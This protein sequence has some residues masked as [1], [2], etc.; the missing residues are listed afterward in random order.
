MG[1]VCRQEVSISQGVV[2]LQKETEE[3]FSIW[4]RKKG[5]Q[6]KNLVR[7]GFKAVWMN[8]FSWIVL[9]RHLLIGIG[10][11]DW[12]ATDQI[13]VLDETESDPSITGDQGE[14]S[15]WLVP[16]W[17]GLL[18]GRLWGAAVDEHRE[19]RREVGRR[20]VGRCEGHPDR[21]SVQRRGLCQL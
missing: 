14:L 6:G 10:I 20:E 12:F 16:R 15:L 7:E 17:W 3:K 11:S 21:G 4:K 8:S 2:V 18:S 5:C 19:E 13:Q 9:F 1:A